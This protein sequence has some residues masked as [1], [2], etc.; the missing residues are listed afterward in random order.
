MIVEESQ[1]VTLVGAGSATK[2]EIDRCLA[3]GPT[4][5]AADGGA[6]H[7][8]AADHLPTA[9]IGDMD[10]LPADMRAHIPADRVH[11]VGEQDS[12]DF[13]KAL[14][15]ISAALVLGVGF[16][17]ARL[18]HQLAC[19]NVLVRQPWQRCILLSD[20]D[21]A[22]L[23]PPRLQ[24]SLQAG[25]RVSLFPLGLVEGVSDGLKWPI[26]GLTFTPDGRIGT[27]NEALGDIDVTVT[28]PKM[29]VILP[30]AE[31]ENVAAALSAQPG[32]WP[33]P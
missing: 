21:I 28:G 3:L 25:T 4:L 17:G 6:A 32:G 16:T 7:C 33:A 23:A 12:T 9:V 19:Y 13:D 26:G 31:L 24:L 15:N 29:L 1:T 30:Q 2:A 27:S 18:D 11:P 14:R 8:L 20:T 10:S 22:F 5:V